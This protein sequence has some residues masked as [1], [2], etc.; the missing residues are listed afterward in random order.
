MHLES[1]HSSQQTDVRGELPEMMHLSGQLDFEKLTKG[2]QC[3]GIQAEIVAC[4]RSIAQTRDTIRRYYIVR[5]PQLSVES[6][7]TEN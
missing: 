6:L 2:T 4:A 1:T 7:I 5:E 3:L